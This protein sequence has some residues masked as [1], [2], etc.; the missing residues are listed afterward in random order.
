[1]NKLS[2]PGNDPFVPLTKEQID[3]YYD[4]LFNKF[5]VQVKREKEFAVRDDGTPVV[6]VKSFQKMIDKLEIKESVIKRAFINTNSK[7]LLSNLE[8]KPLPLSEIVEGIGPVL[9][10]AGEI[11]LSRKSPAPCL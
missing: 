1:M 3:N 7:L 4:L 11:I 2:P 8:N 9:A 10:L 6:Q 5:T